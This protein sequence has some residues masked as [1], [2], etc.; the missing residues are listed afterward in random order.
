MKL[1]ELLKQ[2]N[3]NIMSFPAFKQLEDFCN[4]EG[5]VVNLCTLPAELLLQQGITEYYAPVIPRGSIFNNPQDII[6]ANL[7]VNQYRIVEVNPQNMEYCDTVI[8]TRHK[9]TIDIIKKKFSY[10]TKVLTGNVTAEDIQGRNV[11]G[12]LPPNLI[13]KCNAYIAMSIK[14]YNA[15][16]G[17][18]T[19]EQIEDR[20]IMGRP[21]R[22][23]NVT[24]HNDLI[25]EFLES[26]LSILKEKDTSC[27]KNLEY[28]DQLRIVNGY[29]NRLLFQFFTRKRSSGYQ[30]AVL[31]D[32][33]YG[34]RT[35][36][37]SDTV[38][39]PCYDYV[40]M[41]I[42][43]WVDESKDDYTIEELSVDLINKL[44]SRVL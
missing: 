22:L 31:L 3:V 17:D 34:I 20:L 2:Y 42:S 13:C 21:I 5:E 44:L 26:T 11:V 12:V 43:Y 24:G 29:Y 8:V 6:D 16:E 30:S 15:T 32:N 36:M 28:E 4:K 27:F 33:T 39:D 37:Y 18:L 9:A 35:I 7:D 25:K 41:T 40:D 23:I 1:N 38:Y 19:K 14:D 10:V